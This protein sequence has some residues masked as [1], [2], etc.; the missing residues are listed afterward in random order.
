MQQILVNESINSA[1]FM[2]LAYA[3]TGFVFVCVVTIFPGPM[4]A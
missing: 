1:T 4:D 3:L 2:E